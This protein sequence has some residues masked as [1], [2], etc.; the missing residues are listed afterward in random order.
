LRYRLFDLGFV[1]NRAALYSILTL[2]AVGTLTAVNWFTQHVA[3]ARLSSALQPIAAVLIGLGFM[4]ARAWTQRALERFFFHAR[5]AVEQHI[6]ATIKGF[7][8]VEN[9]EAL[10]E[11]LTADAATTFE[12]Q[13]AAVFRLTDTR[14]ER[15]SAVGWAA[16]DLSSLERND[17]FIRRLMSDSPLSLQAARWHPGGLPEEPRTPV[18]AIGLLRGTVLHGVVLYGRHVN[19]TEIDPE[20]MKL[21]RNLCDAAASAYSVA[22]MRSRIEKLEYHVLALE[23][24]RA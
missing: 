5:F 6:A 21:L 9:P 10:D 11:S 4:R 20:E 2:A 15:T 23:T 3:D 17:E 7:S 1:I 24:Q 22:A 8:I 16:G 19:G 14:L 18:V 13:S 12:L